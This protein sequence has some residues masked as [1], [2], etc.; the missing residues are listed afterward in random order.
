[1]RTDT[2]DMKA[3]EKQEQEPSQLEGGSSYDINGKVSV[4]VDSE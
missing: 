4:L 2:K 3:E 1:M